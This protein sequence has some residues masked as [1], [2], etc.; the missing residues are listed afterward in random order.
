MEA[1]IQNINQAI[2]EIYRQF[3][4]KQLNYSKCEAAKLED[5][6][7]WEAE[8]GNPLPQSYKNF[9][10]HNE[11][12]FSVAYNYEILSLKRAK[13]DWL[14]MKKHLEAGTFDD[15]RVE[16]HINKGFGNWEGNRIQ[17]VWW[18]IQWIPFAVDS[19]ENMLC[20]DLDPAEKGKQHQIISMEIQDGQGPFINQ[21]YTNFR[22]CLLKNLS[23]LQNKKYYLEDYGDGIKWPSIDPY[24]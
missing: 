9:L 24:V 17:Q 16:H 4:E 7:E 22:D 15:G 5:I 10:L 11:Y 8:I 13:S 2:V 19:C 3:S 12:Q 23:Y 1:K 18:S 14:M 21:E 6:N 20:I